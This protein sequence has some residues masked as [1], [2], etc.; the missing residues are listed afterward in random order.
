MRTKSESGLQNHDIIRNFTSQNRAQSM[1][2][3]MTHDFDYHANDTNLKHSL[4]DN[5]I[6][7]VMVNV[8]ISYLYLVLTIGQAEFS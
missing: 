2:I 4:S 3:Q 7:Y 1:L 8:F 6:V 5:N